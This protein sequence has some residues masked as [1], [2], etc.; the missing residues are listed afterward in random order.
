M[1][2]PS[3]L[4]E[5]NQKTS[6]PEKS[7]N[8]LHV[9]SACQRQHLF[10]FSTPKKSSKC[11]GN[12]LT[13]NFSTFFWLRRSSDKSCRTRSLNSF[14]FFLLQQTS[15]WNHYSCFALTFHS[16]RKFSVPE[17]FLK[18]TEFPWTILSLSCADKVGER[19]DDPQS[20]VQKLSLKP[21]FVFSLVKKICHM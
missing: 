4:L 12:C 10:D 16:T 9:G 20:W 17:C 13:P 14:S 5:A 8:V 2:Q 11:F 6:S 7:Q 19:R 18:Q 3:S 21:G 1:F 15:A